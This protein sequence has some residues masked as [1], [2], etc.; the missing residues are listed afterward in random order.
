MHACEWQHC[1]WC[2][3][4]PLPFRC[5]PCYL[6]VH[7]RVVVSSPAGHRCQ[8]RIRSIQLAWRGRLMRIPCSCWQCVVYTRRC[9][10]PVVLCPWRVARVSPKRFEPCP[11]CVEVNLKNK[12][13]TRF[14][15]TCMALQFQ[16]SSPG[17]ADFG[18]FDWKKHWYPVAFDEFTNKVPFFC[19]SICLWSICMYLF[20]YVG[21]YYCMH[22][23]IYACQTTTIAGL[24]T[25]CICMCMCTHV[26]VCTEL[27][28]YLHATGWA[29]GTVVGSCRWHLEGYAGCVPTSP[30]SAQRRSCQ[31]PGVRVWEWIF[32]ESVLSVCV[33]LRVCGWTCL[34][35][36]NRWSLLSPE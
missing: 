21:T 15:G 8:Q 17:D 28:I 34:R 1:G 22:V 35:V 29:T 19:L 2:C 30:R 33:Y 32:F 18:E 12:N 27:A 20:M 23:R 16:V 13:L 25:G 24:I 7:R 9:P 5:F 11:I 4:H 26:Y 10:K 3:R 6:Q 36:A 14:V 31:Q